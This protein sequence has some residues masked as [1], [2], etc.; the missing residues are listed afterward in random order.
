MKLAW[1]TD[2][3]LNFLRPPAVAAFLSSL[4]EV[5]A[6][7]FLLGGDVGEAE[8]VDFYLDSL[9]SV[10]ARPIYFV[11]GNHD[12]YRGSLAG[13]RSL[14]PGVPSGRVSWTCTAEHGWRCARCR[15]ANGSRR[16]RCTPLSSVSSCRAR[17]PGG[18]RSAPRH[19]GCFC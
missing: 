8:D 10:L 19:C 1:L 5:E 7:A 16:F 15:R 2:L 3:H 6:D 12:F 14:A 9:D 13:V 4:A 17:R 11:L 18:A